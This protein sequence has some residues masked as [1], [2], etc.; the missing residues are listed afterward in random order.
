LVRLIASETKTL[1]HGLRVGSAS[2][3]GAD[4]VYLFKVAEVPGI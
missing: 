2:E 1:H 4:D 3:G